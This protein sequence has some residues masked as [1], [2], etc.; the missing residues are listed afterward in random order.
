MK[1][2]VG[3]ADPEAQVPVLAAARTLG[4][5]QQDAFLPPDLFKVGTPRGAMWQSLVTNSYGSAA[6][7]LCRSQLL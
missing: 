1:I 6:Q 4:T 5:L 3:A 2:N 7:G